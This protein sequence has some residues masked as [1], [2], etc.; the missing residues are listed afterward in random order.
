MITE[1]KYVNG[2]IVA[3]DDNVGLKEYEY[4]DNIDELL[5]QEN[6]VEDIDNNLKR[7]YNLKK[8]LEKYKNN[9]IVFFA[10]EGVVPSIAQFLV[11]MVMMILYTEVP[12]L[13]GNIILKNVILA[14]IFA[15]IPTTLFQFKKYK[16]ANELRLI[17]LDEQ[18]K[19]F[20]EK[21]ENEKQKLNEL[22]ENKRAENISKNTTNETLYID[23]S[24]IENFSNI[25]NRKRLYEYYREYCFKIKRMSEK[26]ELNV[27]LEDEFTPE[28]IS[29][30]N[31]MSESA[32]KVL[33]KRKNK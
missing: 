21:L 25:K 13:A 12:A 6:I 31:E 16:K 14:W 15:M 33:T 27:M 22:R 18:I 5:K 3:I 9:F 23:N 10:D 26:R 28:E 20:E 8:Y 1:Y 24:K 19:E 4:Q 11:T 30:L 29:G 32:N 2:K 17:N 7:L